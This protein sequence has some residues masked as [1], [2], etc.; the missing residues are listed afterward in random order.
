MLCG[1]IVLSLLF[2]SWIAEQWRTQQSTL[3]ALF[4]FSNIWFLVD[5][6]D[7]FSPS[8]EFNLLL[9]TWSLSVEEQFYIGFALVAALV[10]ILARAGRV[11]KRQVSV[12]LF[13]TIG[14]SIVI[15]VRLSA[16]PPSPPIGFSLKS[17]VK[18]ALNP[19]YGTIA[20]SWQFALGILMALY[21]PVSRRKAIPLSFVCAVALVVIMRF[22]SSSATTNPWLNISASVASA[23]I[24]LRRV[25]SPSDRPRVVRSKLL[26]LLIAIGDR[27]YSLYL[28]HWPFLVVVN[29]FTRLDKELRLL[30]AWTLTAI[31]ADL[32]YRFVELRFMNGADRPKTSV[33]RLIAVSWS[34]VVGLFVMAWLVFTPA[35]SSNSGVRNAYVNRGCDPWRNPCA[36]GAIEGGV[37]LLVGDSHAM[38]VS[39]AVYE[40]AKKS[41]LGV[42]QC[43]RECETPEQV[44]Q[45]SRKYKVEGLVVVRSW[46]SWNEEQ[47][48]ELESFSTFIPS[49][50]TL[51]AHDNPR[52]PE[53]V[54]PSVLGPR[55]RGVTYQEALEQ[56][57]LSR[58]LIKSWSVK[59]GGSTIDFLQDVCDDK[60]CA[61]SDDKG[62]FYIDDNHLS[63]HGLGLVADHLETA[64]LQVIN[65]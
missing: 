38:A 63:E 56:Q 8:N 36:R 62:L 13:S 51:V 39:E 35:L 7:Y 24:C 19:F 2:E 58:Q 22:W 37:V 41:G 53:W 61:V 34:S 29:R 54:P 46:N 16:H 64:I 44:G 14:L 52:F 32:S 15:F 4:S 31:V 57:S 65:S 11:S 5:K 59:S 26:K 23:G 47:I 25:G 50:K 48:M 28:W 21:P 33:R 27:S 20:R 17:I 18:V 55:A 9:H 43:V 30:L 3:V 1:A 42:V 6:V 40:I 12:V 60:D 10:G 49:T 45:L